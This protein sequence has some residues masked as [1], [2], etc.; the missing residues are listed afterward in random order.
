MTDDDI[1]RMRVLVIDLRRAAIEM[2][3]ENVL[4]WGNSSTDA[5][6]TIDALL[7]ERERLM[8]ENA[9]IRELMNC[10]N[11]GGWTDSLALKSERDALQ[12]ALESEREQRKIVERERDAAEEAAKRLAVEL[13][14]LRAD[15]ER[16]HWAR[17]WMIKQGLLR[18]QECQPEAKMGVGWWYVF[19]KVYGIGDFISYGD[20]AD[21]AIDAAR[22]ETA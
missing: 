12:S 22:K 13:G 3:R 5:A 18:H 20:T 2:A 19:R 16:W 6:D 8:G 10:Y 9:A 21:A 14:V 7:A 17:D 1:K 4:G 15:A 11:L